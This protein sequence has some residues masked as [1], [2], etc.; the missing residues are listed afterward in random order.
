M[1]KLLLIPIFLSLIGCTSIHLTPDKAIVVPPVA[2]PEPT[3]ERPIKVTL[4]RDYGAYTG[5]GGTFHI[6]DNGERV[7]Q[8]ESREMTTYYAGEGQHSITVGWSII[9]NN[10]PKATEANLVSGN[11]STFNKEDEPEYHFGVSGGLGYIIRAK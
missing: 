3:K 10:A 11:F 7:G 8:L 5:A 1:K 4:M 2:H 6:F 9:A